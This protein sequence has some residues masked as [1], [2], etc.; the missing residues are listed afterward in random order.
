MVTNVRDPSR[1]DPEAPS[2]GQIVPQW[3]RGTE[4]ADRFWMRTALSGYNGF[5]LIAADFQRGECF[6]ASNLRAHPRRL[7]RGTY[8][9]SNAALDTAWPKTTVLKQRL[10][11]A[12]DEADSVDALAGALFTALGDRQLAADNDLPATGVSLELER[13]LSSAFIRMPERGYGTRCST[14]VISERVGRHLLTH[15]ME[16]SYTASGAVAL[17]R[18]AT[19]K[20]WP[21]RYSDEAPTRLVEPGVVSDAPRT[22]VRSLLKPATTPRRSK[23]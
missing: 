21:P 16:R 7:E 20:H 6:W 9:V 5:N 1:I 12:L 8:G 18:Q 2:R 19:L 13:T 23:P 3:L 15:V 17:L 4:P 22:R 14:L 10:R 11:L